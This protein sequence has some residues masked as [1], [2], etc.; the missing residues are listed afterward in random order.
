MHTARLAMTVGGKALLS[1]VNGAAWASLARS[2]R[3]DDSALLTAVAEVVERTL[4]AVERV[5][6]EEVA[7]GD[8]VDA[9]C[10]FAEGFAKAV[11]HRA[12]ACRA[13]LLGR[14]PSAERRRH[15]PSITVRPIVGP[16]DATRVKP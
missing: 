9:Q 13:E 10:M 2:V 3:I 14:G 11:Q 1:E 16:T 8:L 12:R 7:S 4:Q 15:R 6:A 5:V